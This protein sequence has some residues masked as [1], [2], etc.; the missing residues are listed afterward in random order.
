MDM[1]TAD[2]QGLPLIATTRQSLSQTGAPHHKKKKKV[3][4]RTGQ[5]SITR[6]I[7]NYILLC[8]VLQK[9]IKRPC[10]NASIFLW[11]CCQINKEKEKQVLVKC[12]LFSLSWWKIRQKLFSFV[13][14]QHGLSGWHGRICARLL[15]QKKIMS[16]PLVTSV[17]PIFF[18]LLGSYKTDGFLRVCHKHCARQCGLS[19]FLSV[20]RFQRKSSSLDYCQYSPRELSWKIKET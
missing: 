12:C 17:R 18:F 6:N 2:R 15:H 19:R 11:P 13:K 10:I 4:S 14:S 5:H 8:L 9:S 7:G 20:G 3:F 1:A 16:G